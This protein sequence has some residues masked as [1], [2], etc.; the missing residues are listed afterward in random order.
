[1]VCISA[2]C[3]RA[4]GL[5]YAWLTN[6][7]KLPQEESEPEFSK[8]GTVVRLDGFERVLKRHV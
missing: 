5:L 6:A 1:M 7:S 2:L 3:S 4:V 8:L